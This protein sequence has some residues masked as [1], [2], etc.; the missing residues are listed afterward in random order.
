VL[1]SAYLFVPAIFFSYLLTLPP[2]FLWRDSPEFANVA[3]SL[4][5]AHPAGFPTY[6]LL[7]KVLTFLPIGNIAFKT[8]LASAVFSLLTVVLL[9]AAL[10]LLINRVYPSAP[11]EDI[12]TSSILASILFALGP[13]GWHNAI[14]AEV[15]TLNNLFIAGLIYLVLLWLEGFDPRWLFLSAFLYGL[16]AGNHATVALFLPGLLALYFIK[17]PRS[18]SSECIKAILFFP[19]GL[20]VYLYLQFGLWQTL[21]MIGETLRT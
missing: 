15:Y 21:L 16:S 6:S 4:S 11:S 2:T 9:N 20:S 19:L 5:I 3:F 8:N 13:I 1:S 7:V 18:I 12:Q 17:R 10:K 14:S